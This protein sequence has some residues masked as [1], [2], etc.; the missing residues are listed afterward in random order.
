MLVTWNVRARPRRQ[1]AWGGRP[2]TSVAPE[3]DLS[4][5]VREIAGDQVEEGGLAG[6]VR[7]DDRAQIALGHG[8]VHAVHGLDAAEM[9]LE[10]DGAE[11]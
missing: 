10:S 4:R 6:A 7:P 5:V 3:E 11:D 9:L 2:L 1:S 8:E